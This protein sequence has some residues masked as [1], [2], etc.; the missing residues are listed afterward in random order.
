VTQT[1]DVSLPPRSAV[2][3]DI[4][5]LRREH[6]G[7]LLPL[8]RDY[9]DFYQVPPASVDEQRNRAHIAH[10]LTHPERGQIFLLHHA[11][12]AQGF[13]TIYYSYS[14]TAARPIGIINDLYVAPALRGL[15][16]GRRLLDY[17]I[18]FLGQHGISIVEWAT[19]PDNR[20]AQRLYDQYTGAGQWYVY[21]LNLDHGG[22]A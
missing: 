8:W 9:Q 13:A 15:G 19:L 10:I 14:S 20:R 7:A 3:A 6:I 11:G 5:P 18:A 2:R 21:R 1:A 12:Q 22:D 4:A 16:L 17:C